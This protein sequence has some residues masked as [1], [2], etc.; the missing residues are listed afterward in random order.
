MNDTI[1]IQIESYRSRLHALIRRGLDARDALD[2]DPSNPAAL[3][4]ARRWQQECGVTVNELSRGSKVHWLA[5]AFSDAFLVRAPGTGAVESVPPAE[6]VQRLVAVLG[7]AL[8]SLSRE[9]APRLLAS[10]GAPSPH[11][12][13]FV[14]NPDLRPVLEQAYHDG[15]RAFEQ[16]DHERALLTYCGILEAIVTDALERKLASDSQPADMPEG[17]IA[18]WSFRTRLNV[19]ETNGLIGHG[20][21]R[22]PALGW[23]YRDA[24]SGTAAKRN[25][26][27]RD[28]RLTGQVLHVIMR[29]LNPGR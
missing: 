22:L 19:A 9:D 4:E 11:R 14:H 17:S 7:Q 8:V 2:A 18:D 28:A 26:S 21:A 25:V 6:I 12:F 15:R 10:A 16:G 27:E 5:R 24:E 13:D 20:C 29:D 1:T 23:S 3:M